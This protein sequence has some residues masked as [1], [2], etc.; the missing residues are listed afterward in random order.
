MVAAI[1]LVCVGCGD[2]RPR[3]VPVSGQ[4]LIDGKPLTHG[5][6]RFAA[7][8]NRPSMGRIGTD[9]RFTLTCYEANDGAI[10]G[11]HRVAIM[12]Q[13]PVNGSDQVKWHAPRKYASYSTS[14]IT[15]EI[16]EPTDSLSINLTW[17]GEKPLK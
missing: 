7:K 9:G 3:I 15:Q 4:V 12:S 2:S 6:V 16:T 11:N 10:V 5:Y 13:E 8:G 1:A 14:G 17:G